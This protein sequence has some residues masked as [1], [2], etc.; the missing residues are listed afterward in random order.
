MPLHRSGRS[1]TGCRHRIAGNNRIFRAKP[2]QGRIGYRQCRAGRAC[3]SGADHAGRRMQ[4]LHDALPYG[5]DADAY[6]IGRAAGGARSSRRISRSQAGKAVSAVLVKVKD[7]YSAQQVASNIAKATGIKSLGYVYPG[8]IT[9]TTKTNLKVI[10]RYVAVFI[11]VF[12][13]MGLVVMLAVFSSAMNER[14]RE[15]AAYRILGAD[16][17]TLVGII[18]KESATIGAIGGVIGVT[19]T[20]LVVFP[21]SGLIAKELQLPYLQIGVGKVAVLIVVALLFAV[22]TGLVAS[23][24]TAVRLSAPQA[25][26]TLRKGE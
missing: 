13:T 15:F 21:F 7:G 10:I 20:S 26:L 25:Y 5:D 2:G 16:R 24:A 3:R 17:A 18:V 11:T 23:L 22:L 9:A 8:G 1:G 4:R 14:K 12:W 6:R 19:C